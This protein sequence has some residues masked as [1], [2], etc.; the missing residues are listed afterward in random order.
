M[1]YIPF[2]DSHRKA[3]FEFFSNMASPHFSISAN[4]EINAFL[5][6]LKTH[7]LPFNISVVYAISRTANHLE[8]FKQRVRTNGIIE[9]AVIHPSY[10]IPTKASSVFSFCTVNYL[11]HYD[12]F[13]DD[14]QKREAYMQT[15]PSFKDEAGRDDYIFLSAIPW[16]HFTGFNHAMHIPAKDSVPRIVWGK[17]KEL[18][19]KIQLPI[20]V[21]AHHAVIDGKDIGQF[22]D[23][24]QILLNSFDHLI[25]KG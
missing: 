3:H 21:Q 4:V 17:Y 6:T 22:F 19:G 1:K 16:I 11:D 7:K 15:D 23:D 12:Q 10:S 18:N 9:H 20:S 8:R 24:L 13:K 5:K 2:E 25:K 14:A